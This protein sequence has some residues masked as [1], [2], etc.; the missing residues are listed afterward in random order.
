MSHSLEPLRVRFADNG[1]GGRSVSATVRLADLRFRNRSFAVSKRVDAVE[2]LLCDGSTRGKRQFGQSCA[3]RGM[4]CFVVPR[5]EQ[6]PL[7]C[8]RTQPS[9]AGVALAYQQRF[10]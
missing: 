3:R 10:L 2:K 5:G 6:V 8:L 9:T 4:S 7:S 1:M